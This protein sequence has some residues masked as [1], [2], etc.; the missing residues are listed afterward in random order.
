MGAEQFSTPVRGASGTPISV[1]QTGTIET[2][3]YSTGGAASGEQ[4]AD[5]PINI[6]P[7]VVIQEL[8][9]TQNS[10]DANIEIHT[11]GGDVFYAFRGASLGSRDKIEI[12]KI[13]ISDPQGAGPTTSVEWYGE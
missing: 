5:Y 6:N 13:V 3:N 8:V 11:T 7:A 2:D 1:A 4:A 10:A 12:D 9:V